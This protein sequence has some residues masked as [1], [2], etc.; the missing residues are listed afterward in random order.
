MDRRGGAPFCRLLDLSH[1][2]TLV[3]EGP[4]LQKSE[5]HG[6]HSGSERLRRSVQ[7][8]Y[9]RTW[10]VCL[11][12]T[13]DPRGR[14]RSEPHLP[15]AKCSNDAVASTV[16]KNNSPLPPRSWFVMRGGNIVALQE[17]LGHASLTMTRRYAHQAPDHLGAEI[18]KTERSNVIGPVDGTTTA[19]ELE[20]AGPRRVVAS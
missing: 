7:S 3:R 1:L 13:L 10:L 16:T 9:R 4:V 15:R 18:A 2:D 17:I 20:A 6:G 12:D 11:P 14:R 19:Q 5:Q 8:G